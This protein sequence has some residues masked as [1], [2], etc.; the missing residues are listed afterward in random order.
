MV[1]ILKKDIVIIGAG[2]TGLT[3]AY[4]LSKYK[5]D[6]IV[7]EKDMRAGG[8]INT[9]KETGFIYETGPNSGILSTIE[10]V[11]LFEDL[12]QV[13]RL[14]TANE[15]SKKRLIWKGNSWKALPTGLFSAVFTPLFTIK[16]KFRILG[17]P[18]R[19]PGTNPEES[20]ADLVRRR[21]GKSFLEYA[22]DPFIS[23]IYAG[24]PEKIV[25]KYALPKLYQLEN[26]YGSFI[27]GSFKKM[28]NRDKKEKKPTR[29]VF[30]VLEGL[31]N[32]IEALVN[33]TGTENISLGYTNISVQPEGGNFK[34]MYKNNGS[35]YTISANK[36]ITTVGGYALPQILPFIPKEEIEN[37]A[38]LNYAK[39]VQVILGFN[40]WK[41]IPL[42]AFG[43]L[44]PSVEK[45]NILG[46]L[47]LSSLFKKRAPEKG[48]LLSVF[49]G[50]MRRPEVYEMSE[51][52]ITGTVKKEITEMMGLTEFNPDLI[53][54]FRYAHAIPQYEASSGKRLNM[55]SKIQSDYPGLILAGNI[56]DGIGMSDR[57]KQ[58]RNIADSL[59]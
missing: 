7:L 36:V 5:K 28:K 38:S 29:E 25:T 30:S 21:L 27:K 46:V 19:K 2:I 53:K 22:V 56:R 10:A 40:D 59:K 57:I 20:V 31:S 32:L 8:V 18:F 50:G 45:R 34:I 58:A 52:E 24:N 23:G 44:V 49:M 39:V 48:A 1:N 43:G 35:D 42:D 16:D 55:I 15:K 4:Y 3:A 13:C 6:L 47:Y 33:E 41:G 12:N 51:K 11:Q 26:E 17:E 37:I 14:E 54:I 9:N